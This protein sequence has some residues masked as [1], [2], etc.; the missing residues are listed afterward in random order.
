MTKE[1]YIHLKNY[2]LQR[3]PYFNQGFSNVHYE[4]L[5]GRITADEHR[6]EILAGVDDHK[7]NYFYIRTEDGFSYAPLRQV[8]NCRPATQVYTAG[9]LVAVVRKGNAKDLHYNLLNTLLS[10]RGPDESY[11]QPVTGRIFAS[12]VIE[13]EFAS[14]EDKDIK[15]IIARAAL[16]ELTLVSIAFRINF[17]VHAANETCYKTPCEGC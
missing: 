4:R 3:N 14:L 17:E 6:V 10:Y 7:G 8:S 5:T 9:M 11:T 13:T 16:Q 15:S 1:N 12:D 2:I